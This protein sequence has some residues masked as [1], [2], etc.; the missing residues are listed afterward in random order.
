M[1]S[2]SATIFSTIQTSLNNANRTLAEKFSPAPLCKELK[3]MKYFTN[4]SAIAPTASISIIAGQTSLGVEPI[5]NIYDSKTNGTRDFIKNRYLE[6]L[7][8]TKNKNTQETWNT[9]IENRGSVQNLDCLTY[10]EKQVFKTPFE[11]DQLKLIDLDCKR[12]EFIYQGQS[13]NIFINA[14]IVV[15]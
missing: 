1:V 4:I 12:Q 13:I 2:P 14:D 7:L 3:S 15:V 9:I 6:K 8:E 11:I 10:D 5:N